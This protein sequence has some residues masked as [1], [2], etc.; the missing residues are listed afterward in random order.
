MKIRVF[1]YQS[2][3]VSWSI[4]VC[5]AVLK[6][7]ETWISLN[8]LLLAFNVNVYFLPNS[9]HIRSH[10]KKTFEN[11]DEA[12]SKIFSLCGVI[13]LLFNERIRQNSPSLVLAFILWNGN[14]LCHSW[15]NFMWW[16][17]WPFALCQFSKKLLLASNLCWIFFSESCLKLCQKGFFEI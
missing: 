8:L 10:N 2:K 9:W 5:S 13:C 12:I 4:I 15:R 17:A 6:V 3:R 11:N 14:P 7:G 16:I 1:F